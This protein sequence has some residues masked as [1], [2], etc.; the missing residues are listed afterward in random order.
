M[1]QAF[2][3]GLAGL[4]SFSSGLNNVSNNIA[5]MNT[6]GYRG[7]DSFLQAL[8][9][10]QGS[11]G[12]GAQLSGTS[13]RF[14]G[15]DIRQTGNNFDA[16]INGQGFFVLQHEGKLF[17]TRSGR[18]EFNQENILIEQSSGYAVMQL[19]KEGQLQNIS[20]NN[21]LVAKPTP[22]TLIS[23]TGNLSPNDDSHQISQ[24]KVINRLGEEV[25][26]SLRFSRESTTLTNQ[27]KVEV[28]DS[29]SQLLQQGSLKFG[30]DGTPE[31]GQGLLELQ[32]PDS[33]G[34]TSA[35]RLQ[36]GSA[37]DFSGLTNTT[38][39]GNDSNA[40]VYKVDGK[41]SGQLLSRELNDQG[42]LLLKYNN[43]DEL[44]PVRL[45]LADFE[46]LQSLQLATGTLFSQPGQGQQLLGTAGEGRFQKL[47]V[48]SVELSNVDLSQEFADML[49]IQ[50]G[51]QSS[52]RILNVANQMLEQLYDNTR[53]R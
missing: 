43:G 14:N 40:T 5:N 12:Y 44:T 45:A 48:R 31:A 37:G 26:L 11:P 52:S 10:N 13:Y 4:N 53:G 30:P 39:T 21:L 25:T 7:T 32:I 27:W 20:L 49:V 1:L 19:T 23:L 36:M 33:A 50:R 34:L 35:V 28:F 3:T 51:Y 17:Y 2:Y 46:H 9:G 6:L 29:K 38:A 16:A 8:G 41:K 42:Q 18:F 15:G 47:A 24:L 22:S